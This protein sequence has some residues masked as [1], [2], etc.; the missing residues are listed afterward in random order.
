MGAAV[1]RLGQILHVS[2]ARR[3]GEE[4]KLKSKKYIC[5]IIVENARNM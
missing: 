5:K 3:W 1:P 4:D 2:W